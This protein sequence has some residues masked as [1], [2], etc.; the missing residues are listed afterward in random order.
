MSGYCHMLSVV[1]VCDANVLNSMQQ[2]LNICT[3]FGVDYDVKFNDTKSIAIRV[4]PRVN[5][6]RKPLQLRKVGLA[7][8][9]FRCS[10]EH[11]KMFFRVFNS[12]FKLYLR[13]EQAAGSDINTVELF[14]SYCLPNITY[15]YKALPLS[16]PTFVD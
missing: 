15:A 9:Y 7:W 13:K 1:V 10:F 16:K 12:C 4:D 2:V 8:C 5:V 11:V 14:K 6:A 3:E